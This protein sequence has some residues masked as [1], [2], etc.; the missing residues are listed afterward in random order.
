M[1]ALITTAALLAALAGASSA[2]AAAPPRPLIKAGQWSIDVKTVATDAHFNTFRVCMQSTG[3]WYST[4]QVKGGG[5][6]LQSANNVLW[7]GNMAGVLSDAATLTASSSTSMTGYLMQWTADTT[8]TTN[9]A[10][11]NVYATTTWTFVSDRCDA[12]F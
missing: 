7:R 12:P 11:E 3:T 9:T 5:R 6:W 8:D 4:I 1:K 2:E 10:I